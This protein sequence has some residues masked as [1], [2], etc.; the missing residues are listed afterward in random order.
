MRTLSVEGAIAKIGRPMGVAWSESGGY[1]LVAD[2]D[3]HRILKFDLD[4]IF[5]K[6]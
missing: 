2:F 4:L 5:V 6:K 3:T 1:L